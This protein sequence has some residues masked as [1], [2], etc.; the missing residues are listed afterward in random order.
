[1]QSAHPRVDRAVL[2]TARPAIAR[3]SRGRARCSANID[4][5]SVSALRQRHWTWSGRQILRRHR[6]AQR[7]RA[8]PPAHAELAGRPPLIAAGHAVRR[9]VAAHQMIRRQLGTLTDISYVIDEPHERAA[10]RHPSMNDAAA[11][12]RQGQHRA[13]RRARRPETTRSP[14]PG[15]RPPPRRR[16]GYR[17]RLGGDA[18]PT[19][20][21]E[22]RR[23]GFPSPP[24]SSGVDTTPE[25]SSRRRQTDNCRTSTT[26]SGV[27][28]GSQP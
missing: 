6:S 22:P 16:G 12:A 1:M 28:C 18:V 25:A 27:G 2:T 5:L 15:S 7:H 21:R 19:D 20:P 26:T 13:R 24:V 14:A 9:R 23:P 4:D 11:A 3:L 8:T 10:P 17:S